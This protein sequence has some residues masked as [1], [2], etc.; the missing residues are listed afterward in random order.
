MDEKRLLEMTIKDDNE[1]K[2]RLKRYKRI[3][4]NRFTC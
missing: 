1:V 4:R 3:I 2:T